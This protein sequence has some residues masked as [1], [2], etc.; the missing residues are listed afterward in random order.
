MDKRAGSRVQYLHVLWGVGKKGD[1]SNSP[2]ILSSLFIFTYLPT[3]QH[4]PPYMALLATRE[5][6]KKPNGKRETQNAEWI[7]LLSCQVSVSLTYPLPFPYPFI[8]GSLLPRLLLYTVK[9]NRNSRKVPSSHPRGSVQ[10]DCKQ[11][12]GKERNG[13]KDIGGLIVHL[14]A[15]L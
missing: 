2:L 1:N 11:R 8:E 3:N 10:I 15:E 14:V 13:K 6:E 5:K 7:S 4:T 9:G 12:S